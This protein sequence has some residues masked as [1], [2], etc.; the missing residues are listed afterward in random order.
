MRTC[1]DRAATAT[2]G[3]SGTRARAGRRRACRG[4]SDPTTLT[5]PLPVP[6][7][8]GRSAHDA[9]SRDVAPAV[10]FRGTG[11]VYYA[12]ST[13][14]PT[15]T[16]DELG[17]DPAA[18]GALASLFQGAGDRRSVPRAAAGA[19]H[20]A[21]RAA[22]TICVSL[23]ILTVGMLVAPELT[24]LWLTIGAIGHAGG[25]VVI[26]TALVAVAR[27]DNEAAG[28]SALVQG[29]GYGI[30]ALGAPIMGALHEATGGWTVPLAMMVVV[31]V[32]YCVALLAAGAAARLATRLTT[33]CGAAPRRGAPRR[34]AS[35]DQADRAA[36]A[37]STSSRA[38][39]STSS[40]S[41]F[42]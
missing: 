33:Q 10:H 21:D 18:A 29:G 28:M 22:L 13:W 39:Y 26:F 11:H 16:A 14:L 27:S 42:A 4:I 38:R 40:M 34:T 35:R 31:A 6:R 19:V 32:L 9:S 8:A 12:L 37:R 23:L 7:A 30:G 41:P 25:F 20:A 24:W 15:I 5:G 36:F 2:G 3:A 17:L 1:D